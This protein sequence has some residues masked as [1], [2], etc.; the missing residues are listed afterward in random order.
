MCSSKSTCASGV[1]QTWH[2]SPRRR[3]T[4]YVFSSDAPASR[5]ARPRSSSSWI[6]A[7]SRSTSSASRSP[8]SAYGE[9]FAVWRISF[10][11][12]R[13]MPAMRRWSRSSACRRR[14]SLL[15]IAP[16][17]AAS[18][19]SASGPRWPS[20]ASAVSGVRSQT[21]A[22]FFFAFSV[23]TSFAPSCELERE[24]GLR[25]AFLAG[26]E[27]L[28]PP[29]GHEVDEEHELAVVGGEEEPLRAPLG[30][31]DSPSLERGRRRVERLERRDVRG[32][33]PRDR[34]RR[35]RPVELAAPRLHLRQL[36]HVPERYSLQVGRS[37]R[38]QRLAARAGR[39]RARPA[40]ASVPPPTQASPESSARM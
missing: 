16:S 33:G 30:A 11:H 39:P 21:P 5:S 25:R 8:E 9:S 31:A 12:A 27:V 28:E 36:W 6:A 10:A 34:G 26:C 19:V 37:G 2:G 17:C 1:P 18:S 4:R 14:E 23:R 15:R 13:P 3:W 35:D 38:R 7:A 29:G 22:R 40:P 32:A 20:S 24:R